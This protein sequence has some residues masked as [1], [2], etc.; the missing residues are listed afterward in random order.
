MQRFSHVKLVDSLACPSFFLFFFALFSK[1]TS[2]KEISFK[3]SEIFTPVLTIH[4]VNVPHAFLVSNP[5]KKII[6]NLNSSKKVISNL[7]S[8]KKIISNLNS[9]KK[10][11]SNLN[12]SEKI[13]VNSNSRKKIII[14]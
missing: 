14:K 5:G 4:I 2:L 3:Q 11:I 12:S 1:A 13:M 6:S 8:S 9:S 10:A 7:N